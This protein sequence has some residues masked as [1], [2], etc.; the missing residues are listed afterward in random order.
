MQREAFIFAAAPIKSTGVHQ[1]EIGIQHREQVKAADSLNTS[2]LH[3]TSRRKGNK[4]CASH[5]DGE[6][7]TEYLHD[8]KGRE[9]TS[10][11]RYYGNVHYEKAF[12]AAGWETS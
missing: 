11:L 12:F 1:E 10:V 9:S 6:G 3:F 5:A 4:F 8:S 2:L 7:N